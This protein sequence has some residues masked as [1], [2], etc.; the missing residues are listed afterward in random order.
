MTASSDYSIKNIKV[1]EGLQAVRRRPAMYIG[2]T[3][4]EGLH[5]L[6]YEVVDNAI[7]EAMAGFCNNVTI[8]IAKEGSV[9]IED[10]GRGIPVEMHESG[11]SGVEVVMT[12]LHAGGKF[13]SKSYKISGGLHGVG[14][15]VVNALAEQLEV[16]VKRDGGQWKQ[17]FERGMPTEPLKRTGDAKKTGTTVSFVPD[18]AVFDTTEFRHDVLTKRFR[19]MAFL[20]SGVRL[21]FVDHRVGEEEIFQYKGGLKEFI[22]YLNK[23]KGLIHRDIVHLEKTVRDKDGNN[24]NVEIAFQFNDTWSETILSFANTINTVIGGKHLQGFRTALTRSFNFY[25]RRNKI[26]KEKDKKR[27]PTGDDYKQGLTA[28]VSVK[29]ADPQF[30]SQTKVRLLNQEIEGIVER[31]VNERLNEY[32]AENPTSARKIVGKVYQAYHARQAAKRA[33]ELVQ[34]KTALSSGDLPAKL[35]DCDKRTPPEDA[36]IYIVE[37]QSAGGNAKQGRDRRFQAILPL[38]GK[39]LNV[40]KARA[41]KMLA[42]DEIKTLIQALGTGIHAD[43]DISKLRYHKVIIMTD[44]DVDGS[45]IRTLLLTF[46]FRQMRPLIENGHI[47]IAQPPLYKVKRKRIEKYVLSEKE[48][49]RELIMLGTDGAKALFDGGAHEIQNPQLRKLLTALFELEDYIV[50][51]QRKGVFFKDYLANRAEDGTFPRFRLRVEQDLELFAYEKEE[52]DGVLQEL[53]ASRKKPLNVYE[54]G[55]SL[56]DRETADVEIYEFTDAGEIEPLVKKIEAFDL[57]IELYVGNGGSGDAPIRILLAEEE[58]EIHCYSLKELLEKLREV[59]SRGLEI[60]RYKGLGEMNPDQLR[61]TA[62]EPAKRTLLRIKLEDEIAADKIFTAL[63]GSAV[64]Q[65][66]EFIE[67]FALEVKNLDV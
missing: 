42:H 30:E 32:V 6:I 40:E 38:K 28:V 62:M 14:V 55:D 34:R 41:D 29:L 9:K 63:M 11:I 66:R 49:R 16:I 24:V 2:N 21:K 26:F 4:T 64:E 7:D 3:S 36:E 15:S 50:T 35:A 56:A 22:K 67:K 23:G 37:G 43:F 47:Y 19:E 59:G 46:F 8:E 53:A 65:R 17:S 10:D 57:P 12:K 5:R 60:Q 39:I 1:L 27:L 48:M 18:E 51:I 54:E 44:A 20:N 52:L 61:E 31:V 33:R 45:H 13:D 58:E 25:G